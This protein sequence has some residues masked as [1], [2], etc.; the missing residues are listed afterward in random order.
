MLVNTPSRKAGQGPIHIGRYLQVWQSDFN[1]KIV[2][3]RSVGTFC[4][5]MSPSSLRYPLAFPIGLLLQLSITPFG[6]TDK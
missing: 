5:T 6:K 3:S 1:E 2:F 4:Q